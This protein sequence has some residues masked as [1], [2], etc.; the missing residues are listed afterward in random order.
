MIVFV[1][2]CADVT[3]KRKVFQDGCHDPDN[4]GHH[5]SAVIWPEGDRAVKHHIF[6]EKLANHVEL[7]GL[8]DAA[9]RMHSSRFQILGSSGGCQATASVLKQ[10]ADDRHMLRLGSCP[11][12]A[13]DL[14]VVLHKSPE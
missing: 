1:S 13:G 14:V 2:L 5:L 4:R 7:A 10:V 12:R 11:D 8:H 3:T 9:K 6:G